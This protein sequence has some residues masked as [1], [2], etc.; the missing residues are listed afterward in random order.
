MS[1]LI[2]I[3]KASAQEIYQ[4]EGG[5]QPYIDKVRKE[6]SGFVGDASSDKGR[7]EIAS[8]AR[9]ISKSKKYLDDTGKDILAELK[10]IPKKIDAERKRMRDILDD[11]KDEISKPL[12]EWKEM[13][14]CRVE[15]HE[16]A[17][18]YIK[19]LG[20]ITDDYGNG[21]SSE[22]LKGALNEASAV[23]VDQSCEEYIDQYQYAV[24]QAILMLSNAIPNVERA[25]AEAAE[26]EA[27]RKQNEAQQQQ[28]R[29]QQIA[30]QAEESAR[31]R[32]EQQQAA[33][34]A[35]AEAKA[36]DVEHRKAINNQ[37]LDDMVQAGLTEVDAKHIIKFIA[38]GKIRN[39][40][41]N[42]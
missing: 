16:N 8:M 2:E 10:A 40:S 1:N 13:E 21:Y 5:L 34:K 3:P 14:R 23:Q 39:V 11:L 20:K 18:K 35:A 30:Q 28:I 12:D 38:S 22:A 29:E 33:E 9:K 36:R 27:L 6:V 4:T 15:G 7:K 25:E 17:I 42:Y 31:R 41:I 37:A 19:D 24:S 32:L 26:L